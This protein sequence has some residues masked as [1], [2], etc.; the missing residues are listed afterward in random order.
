M[1]PNNKLYLSADN[2]VDLK[3]GINWKNIRTNATNNI[4]VIKNR[5]G[6]HIILNISERKFMPTASKDSV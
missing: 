6:K 2:T 5:L 3:N 4:F 1:N